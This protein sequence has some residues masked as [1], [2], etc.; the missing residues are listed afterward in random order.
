MEPVV[1]CSEGEE[2]GRLDWY[3]RAYDRVTTRSEK[4]LLRIQH[5]YFT[6]TTTDD[7]VIMKLAGKGA[8]NVY[9]TDGILAFL[10]T[11]PRSVYSW[12]IVV[13]RIGDNL[14]FDKRDCPDLDLLTVSETA[15]DAPAD[16]G[17]SINSPTM[18][19][20]EAT[21]IN[22]NFSQQ[23]LRKGDPQNLANPTIPF[24]EEDEEV[25]T[26][27]GYRYRRFL[28]PA[29]GG[30]EYRLVVRTEVDGVAAG[31]GG[32][33]EQLTIKAFNEW[34]SRFS[35]GEDWRGKMESQKGALLATE[36]KNNSCKLAKWTVQALLAGADQMK[37]G[38]VS[39]AHARDSTKHVIL[40]TQQFTPGEF[41][42][43][44]T[45]KMDNS[46]A[47][48]KVIIDKCMEQTPGK[49]LI[50]KDPNKV[51]GTLLLYK[52]PDKTFEDSDEDSDDEDEADDEE[53]SKPQ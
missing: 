34:D 29:A 9:A 44:I 53:E 39:R 23:V 50:L 28:L 7:P 47:I 20:Q 48:L 13:T 2:Y 15:T 22:R 41:A 45:L 51:P 43:N 6:I 10:M 3:D 40:G 32:R 4:P 30:G 17:H 27:I 35:G 36:M 33:T 8:G 52:L 38:Y 11:A 18:L 46:W 24:V 5:K 49:Y 31:V 26:S 12:D 16:D 14:F 25:E 42:K 19:A 21:Y 37:F 1:D